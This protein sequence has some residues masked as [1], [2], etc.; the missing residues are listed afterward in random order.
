MNDCITEASQTP[1]V[2]T[3]VNRTGTLRGLRAAAAAVAVAG[4]SPR[5]AGVA[6]EG[7]AAAAAGRSHVMCAAM[8]YV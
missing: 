8:R 5:T 6:A 3:P 4:P 7:A 2:V 1:Q